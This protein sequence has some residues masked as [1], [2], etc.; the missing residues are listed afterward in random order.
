MVYLTVDDVLAIRDAIERE[1]DN[2]FPVRT[3]SGLY[4]A[5]E[6]P[7][8]VLFGQ[9]LF[10]TLAEK[11]GAL[12]YGLVHNH[13]F[14]DGNKRVATRAVRLFLE[15][16]GARLTGSD[17]ELRAYAREI[18]RGTLQREDVVAWV[19]NHIEDKRGT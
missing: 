1:Y 12:L 3:P 13:P 14:W 2:S 11:S 9:E 4:A 15:R 10:E 7:R 5:I 17:H 16:N 18:A 6:A 8:G 19:V